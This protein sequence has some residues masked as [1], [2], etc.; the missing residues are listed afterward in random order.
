M[1]NLHKKR[2]LWHQS[3]RH[4]NDVMQPPP[5][6]KPLPPIIPNN[7]NSNDI[8]V[9]PIKQYLTESNS[10]QNSYNIPPQPSMDSDSK[11][12]INN[13]A[14]SQVMFYPYYYPYYYPWMPYQQIQ[15][16]MEQKDETKIEGKSTETN[17][18]S[19]ISQNNNTNNNNN[20][21]ANDSKKKKTKTK[22]WKVLWLYPIMDEHRNS[23]LSLC[24]GQIHSNFTRQWMSYCKND[25]NWNINQVCEL[26]HTIGS[27]KP[28]YSWYTQEK[29][30]CTLKSIETEQDSTFTSNGFPEWLTK[31]TTKVMNICDFNAIK[32]HSISFNSCELI[33]F[34]RN[35]QGWDWHNDNTYI[36]SKILPDKD[37]SYITLHLL[38]SGNK[39]KK[40][41]KFSPKKATTNTNDKQISLTLENGDILL[42]SGMFQHNYMI[43]IEPNT[44]KNN[45]NN[46]TS[47]EF[48][49]FIWRTITNHIP[50][51]CYHI[52]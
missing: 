23:F 6:M 2:K 41:F 33:Y 49:Y 4:I 38:I 22:G 27:T 39:M 32:K 19:K 21:N 52:K 46:N 43:K 47:Q 36:K 10:N 17:E 29:C 18:I 25:D 8:K 14:M 5:P 45:N 26:Q 37:T 7:G 34:N 1:M 15:T 16:Q 35:D 42:T 24:R 30:R 11:T 31:I 44:I 51:C 48:C 9:D 13:N 28:F 3:R 40:L 12:N 50:T 20:T